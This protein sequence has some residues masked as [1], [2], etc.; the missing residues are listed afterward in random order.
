VL[1]EREL[2]G[3]ALDKKRQLDRVFDRDRRPENAGF[4]LDR[5]ELQ[6]TAG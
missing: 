2:R 4:A 1:F 5:G 3:I 6:R